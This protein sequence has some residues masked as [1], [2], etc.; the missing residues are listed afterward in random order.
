MKKDCWL[1]LTFGFCLSSLWV[2][3]G[4]EEFGNWSKAKYE[5]TVQCQE[6]LAPGSTVVAET[7]FGSITV[8]GADIA[9]CNVIAKI[10]VN[11]ST[12]EQAREIAEKVQIELEQVGDKLTV[13]VE[14]PRLKKKQSIG[15]SFDITVP[16]KSNIECTSSFGA[17][18]L[19]NLSGDV[20]GK[21]S[22]GSVSCE[23]IQGSAQLNTSFGSVKCKDVSGGEIIAK[24]SSGSI[25][26][27]DIKGTAQME[28]SF[29][30]ITC[31]NFSGGDVT[32]K[33]SSGK[34]A[35]LKAS[36][37]ACD[38]QT[39]HG[40]LKASELT[41]DSIKLKSGSGNV[42]VTEASANTAD[43]STSFGRISCKQIACR[44]LTTKSSSGSIDI[45]CAQS[46]PAEITATATTSHG[47]I[48]FSTPPNFV[49]QVELS[50]SYGSIKSD[51]P[52]TI[53]GQVSKKKLTG[54]IGEGKGQL[55]LETKSGSI[56]IK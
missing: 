25:T 23:S 26:A 27:E 56:K 52:I 3:G 30:S 1:M 49:G 38:A 46:A 18:K 39:S 44:N 54:T 40:S 5:K 35:L 7:S 6:A 14:K 47:S 2:V 20:K 41:G 13:K 11:A 21:T 42:D 53:T 31:S 10:S 45:A 19:A 8:T 37:G 9:D 50:T 28:T 48:D 43:I 22:S 12:E 36:F 34:I 4:C 33:T 55:H 15:I 29:G 17:I 51:L 32:L 24:S 16:Q